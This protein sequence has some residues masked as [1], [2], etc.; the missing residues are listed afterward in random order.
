[1][2]KKETIFRKHGAFLGLGHSFLFGRAST[3]WY[4]WGLEVLSNN[5]GIRN[6]LYSIVIPVIFNYM[7]ICFSFILENI[8]KR[9]FNNT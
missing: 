9:I 5:G 4:A 1:L 8:I 7:G 6:P 3:F 2:G